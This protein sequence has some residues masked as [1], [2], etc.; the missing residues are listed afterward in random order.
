MMIIIITLPLSVPAPLHASDVQRTCIPL[1]RE[2]RLRSLDDA[3]QI[4]ERYD[5]ALMST[6]GMSV[7]A[8]RQL[9]EA[10]LEQGGDDSRRARLR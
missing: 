6:K 9:V 1:Y 3:A 10:L 5:L 7:T 4:A 2:R 8:A